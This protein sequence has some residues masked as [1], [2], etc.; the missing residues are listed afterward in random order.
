MPWTDDFGQGTVKLIGLL[1]LLAAVG[2]I[3]PAVLNVAPVVV[4]VAALG[5]A[6]I[7]LGAVVTRPPQGVPESPR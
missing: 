2:L 6:A 5:L 3:L 7:M 4:P 1:E